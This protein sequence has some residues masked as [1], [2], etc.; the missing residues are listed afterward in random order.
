MKQLTD[1][2]E[3]NASRRKFL[4]NSMVAGAVATVGGSILGTGANSGHAKQSD[5]ERKEGEA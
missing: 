2:L 4:K 1:V 5:R 3:R